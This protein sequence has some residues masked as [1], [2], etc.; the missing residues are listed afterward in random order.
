[1]RSTTITTR[2]MIRSDLVEVLEIERLCFPEPWTH[3]IILD[4]LRQRCVG[5]V[6][7]NSYQVRGFVIYE[8][9]K[10]HLTVPRMAVHPD[11]QRHGFGSALMWKLIDK[12]G[13]QR[14]N[15][16]E[17]CVPE[18]CLSACMF[19]RSVGFSARLA[20]GAFDDEDGYEFRYQLRTLE[21]I[22]SPYTPANRV[23]KYL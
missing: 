2:W 18:S 14:R 16:I 6:A 23:A 12:L 20:R 7:E 1:M 9:H 10:G 8:L 4:M 3:D 15:R 5:L 17:V 21:E 11:F 19:L 13:P 22:E